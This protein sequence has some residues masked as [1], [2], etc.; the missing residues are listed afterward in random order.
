V[1]IPPIAIGKK[2]Q[3]ASDTAYLPPEGQE[4]KPLEKGPRRSEGKA[5]TVYVI[6]FS[7]SQFV[8]IGKYRRFLH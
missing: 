7:L 1:N 4:E 5:S 6:L 3:S 2:L 8:F